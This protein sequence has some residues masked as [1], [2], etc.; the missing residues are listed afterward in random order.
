M[1]LHQPAIPEQFPGRL[2]FRGRPAPSR[3]RERLGQW[4]ALLAVIGA[5]AAL[6]GLF[7][8]A[9]QRPETVITLAAVLLGIIM[10]FYRPIVGLYLAVAATILVDT[11]PSQWVHT[12]ISDMGLYRNLNLL[13]MPESVTISMF[14]I[15]VGVALLRAGIGQFHRGQGVRRGPLFWPIVIFAAVVLLGEVNGLSSGGDFKISLWEIRPL[16]YIVGLYFL[17]MNTVTEPRHVR[18]LLW[19]TVAGTA[20][21]CVDAVWRYLQIPVALHPT[22][23]TLVEHDDSLF[24]AVG[25]GLLVTTTL[26][27][28]RLPRGLYP[29]LVVSIP[30]I[31]VVMYLNK[32]RAVYL[33]LGVVVLTLLPICAMSLGPRARRRF[34]QGVGVVALLGLLYVGAFWNGHGILAEPAQVVKSNFQP[35]ERDA[36]SNQYRDDENTNLHHTIA[37]SPIIGVGFGKPMDE[38]VHLVNLQD[39]WALQLYMPHNNMLW[40][41]ERMG[42]IGFGIFWGLIGSSILLVLAC[43]QLGVRRLR[44]LGAEERALQAAPPEPTPGYPVGRQPAQPPGRAGALRT[45]RREAQ[46]C[47]EFLLLASLVLAVLAGLVN[48]AAVDQGLMSF[49][50]TAYTGALLGALAASWQYYYPRLRPL[51]GAALAGATDEE[52]TARVERRRVRFVSKA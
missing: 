50:L 23:F 2:F 5:F 52:D 44:A 28:R 31:L 43:V 33:C 32:R 19:I 40:L 36:A 13:G 12:F 14:E 35:D 39:A 17:A 45:V 20:V 22:I 16:L 11:F 3:L 38:V 6:S 26:W 24:L 9:K 21:R 18:G 27:R 25:A 15:L 34:L 4:A 1:S 41:W 42:I 8:V 48:L 37:R 49:R 30:I 7:I 51:R 47:V 10:T 46:E 29:L